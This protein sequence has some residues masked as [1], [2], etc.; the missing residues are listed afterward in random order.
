M[1]VSARKVDLSL[2]LPADVVRV[3]ETGLRSNEHVYRDKP[4]WR[5]ALKALRDSKLKKCA[6][7]ISKELFYEDKTKVVDPL[8]LRIADSYV[9]G[10]VCVIYQIKC[11]AD[12]K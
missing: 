12:V 1:A 10:S 11:V 5:E 4:K 8:C 6:N 9:A 7:I 2:R 3:K